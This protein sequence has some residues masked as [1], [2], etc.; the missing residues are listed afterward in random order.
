MKNPLY[1]PPEEYE[2]LLRKDFEDLNARYKAG[3]IPWGY[4]V[5]RELSMLRD[6]SL[7]RIHHTHKNRKE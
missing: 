5:G 4:Y 1:V 6:L 2:A 3:E 7:H